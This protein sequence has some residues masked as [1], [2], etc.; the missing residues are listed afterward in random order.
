VFSSG[1]R[2]G[3]ASLVGFII[4]VPPLASDMQWRSAQMSQDANKVEAALKPS[5]LNPLSMFKIN[6][7]VGVFETNNLTDLAHK[8]ALEAIGYNPDSFE[9]W[10]N[11]YRISKSTPEEK[12]LALENMRRLDPLNPDPGFIP[13]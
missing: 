10:R 5:Y 1:L 4:A 8:Y 13:E 9:A 3:I 2:A 7:V 11:L 6:N 12:A